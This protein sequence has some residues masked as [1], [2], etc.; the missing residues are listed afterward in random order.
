MRL[1]SFHSNNTSVE[2]TDEIFNK[3]GGPSGAKKTTKMY[4]CMVYC[5]FHLSGFPL[6]IIFY[7]RFIIRF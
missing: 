2:D 1:N 5:Y 6:Y 3:V 4:V 7:I